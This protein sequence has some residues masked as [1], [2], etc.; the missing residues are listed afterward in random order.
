MTEREI[1]RLECELA[2]LGGEL[3]PKPGWQARVLAATQPAR[4]PWW[5]FAVPALVVAVAAVVIVLVTRGGEP[6]PRPL[7]LA[8]QIDRGSAV[9]RGTQASIGDVVRAKATGGKY[10]AIWIYRG[11]RELVI[12]CPGAPGCT[13]TADA[14]IAEVKLAA[15]GVYNVIAI[16]S[17]AP[18]PAPSGT[19]DPDL[20]GVQKL[21]ARTRVE[22]IDVR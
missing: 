3:E 22:D 13:T 17:D 19:L 9:V 18:L 16:D 4:R 1:E 6:K 8:L 7:A 14:L 21:G 2:K 11:D 12:A 10:R 5:K 20:A 15:P